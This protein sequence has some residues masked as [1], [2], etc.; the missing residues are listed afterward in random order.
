MV[1]VKGNYGKTNSTH[2]PSHRQICFFF[3]A[4][5]QPF[6]SQSLAQWNSPLPVSKDAKLRIVSWNLRMQF[7]YMFGEKN[8]KRGWEG[9]GAVWKE[10][11]PGEGQA[12]GCPVM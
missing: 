3:F 12:V 1:E 10:V 2:K 8:E 6:L 7:Y 5:T 9:I 4:H 11:S